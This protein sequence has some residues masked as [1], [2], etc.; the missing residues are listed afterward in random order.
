MKDIKKIIHEL[1]NLEDLSIEDSTYIFNEIMSG[2]ISDILIHF[3]VGGV[4][5][6]HRALRGT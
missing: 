4:H 2:N 1:Y 6:L 3:V 5:P